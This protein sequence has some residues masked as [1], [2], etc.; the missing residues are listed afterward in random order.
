MRR[1]VR[2]VRTPL[3]LVACVLITSC[4]QRLDSA[5]RQ[6][7][8]QQSLQ[9][10]NG[11]AAPLGNTAPSTSSDGG[12]STGSRP[13]GSSSGTTGTGTTGVVS[14][15]GGTTTSGT[16]S[17]TTGPVVGA[18]TPPGGN[19]G[20]T[21]VGVTATTITLGTVAD[22]TGPQPGLFDGDVAGV[23][24]YFAYVNSQG[25]VFGRTLKQVVAD[26]ALDCNQTSN[27]YSALVDKVF[28]YVGN[29]SLFDNCGT[30]VLKAH[31]KVPDVSFTLTPEHLNNPT[32]YSAQPS[33]PGGRTGPPLD[34]A[35]NFPGTKG[36][37]GGLYPNV[38]G[39]V[40]Q[41]NQ[42]KAM[43]VHLGF[44]I[45]YEQAIPPTTVDYTQY[46][47]GMRQANVKMVI[48][49]NT[50]A[51]NA[52]FV[53]AAQQ[54][55]FVPPVIE[56]PGTMYDPS[57]PAAAGTDV[58]DAYIDTTTALFFNPEEAKTIPGVALYQKWMKTVAP[59][60]TLDQFSVFGWMEAVL[61][62]QALKTAG[63][64]ATQ[65]SLLAAAKNT[66]SVDTGGLVATGD[67]GARRAAQCYLLAHYEKGVWKRFKS[68]ATGFICDKPYYVVSS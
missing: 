6:A 7:L 63:P 34:F 43:L 11:A 36:A 52:K 59:K 38:A 28:A 20:A 46:V 4:G 62:V 2:D 17:G 45:A 56:A 1:T 26:S 23:K 40:A 19:G 31:P 67:P 66:H 53:T 58:P 27:A 55:S 65:S 13:A 15:T 50:A 54:Q 18:S 44:T 12:T 29:M 47:I 42:E 14:T 64:K 3:L 57:F 5:S 9:G 21:D 32:T 8:L 16:T 37:V 39:A 33:I 30:D 68:P 25:G 41:W 49:F 48:L 35:Q 61:F 24:A 60:Q 10:R 22:L 51:N